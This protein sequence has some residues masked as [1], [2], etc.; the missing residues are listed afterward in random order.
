MGRHTDAV[1][2]TIKAA[3]DALTGRHAALVELARN[4]AEQADAA[5]ADGPGTRLAGTYLTTLRTLNAVI[6]DAPAKPQ[7]KTQ[8]QLVR[9]QRE[10]EAS[11]P[12]ARKRQPKRA[13]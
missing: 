10:A 12:A 13:G 2:A 11:K 1:E 3:G 8:L 9:E 6:A 5:G 4:L 7:G